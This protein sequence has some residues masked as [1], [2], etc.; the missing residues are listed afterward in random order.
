VLSGDSPYP[1]GTRVQERE[2]EVGVADVVFKA[3][4]EAGVALESEDQEGASRFLRPIL[5]RADVSLL[6]LRSESDVNAKLKIVCQEAALVI[7]SL[8]EFLPATFVTSAA[9]W[10]IAN[11]ILER[12]GCVLRLSP[13]ELTVFGEIARTGQREAPDEVLLWLMDRV[14]SRESI[15][16]QSEEERVRPRGRN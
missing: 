14:E 5:E 6:N 7:R 11:S 15:D 2:S 9:L 4:R 10:Q 13:S 1:A 16:V 8:G 12:G 3:I